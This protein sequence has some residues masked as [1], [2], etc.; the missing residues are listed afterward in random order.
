M[1]KIIF[2]EI[3]DDSFGAD[4]YIALMAKMWMNYMVADPDSGV[5]MSDFMPLTSTEALMWGML[6][7]NMSKAKE[8]K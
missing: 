6:M 2:F 3:E 7:G 1:T 4:E 8:E 5:S